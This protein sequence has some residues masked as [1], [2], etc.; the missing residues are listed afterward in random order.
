MMKKE[1]SA[2]VL[3]SLWAVAGVGAG[4]LNGLLGAAGGILLVTLL[5]RL[6]LPRLLAGETGGHELAAERRP[7]DRRTADRRLPDRRDAMATALCVMLPVS[8]ASFVMY[9]LRGVRV[10][11]P[12]VTAVL[13]PAAVGGVVGAYLLGRVPR[14]ALRRIFALL[15]VIS[16]LRML[17]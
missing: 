12:L 4:V 3:F 16:G 8:A 11:V 14:E 7:A 10:D 15:V 2:P 9:A 13:L 1:L 17:M 5:P 6:P